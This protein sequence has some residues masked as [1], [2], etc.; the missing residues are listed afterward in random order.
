M[1]W[2]SLARI[3]LKGIKVY[4][5]EPMGYLYFIQVE[6]DYRKKIRGRMHFL[7]HIIS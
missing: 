3:A 2:S 1:F 7:T 6:L 5:Y 4:M